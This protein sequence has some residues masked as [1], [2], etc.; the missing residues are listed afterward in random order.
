[1][2]RELVDDLLGFV[3]PRTCL[4]CGDALVHG[5]EH[6]CLACNYDMPRT[7]LHR[8]PFTR[9]SERLARL[10]PSTPVAAWFYYQRLSPWARVVHSAKYGGRPRLARD[11]GRLFTAEI[12]A[13]GFFD[14]VDCL[15]PVPMHF[16]KRLKRGYN[17]AYRIAL[18]VADVTKLPVD[19]SFYARRGHATQTRRT[20]VERSHNVRA[21]MFDV[22]ADSG[23]AGKRIVVIDDIV[24]TGAT[25][26]AV[27][28]TLL[29]KVGV[30]QAKVLC[31]GITEND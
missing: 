24:T 23:L 17:Q 21:D 4:V 12:V 15:V 31:L 1:M 14:D 20:A 11:L 10:Q 3:V 2:I 5:E 6:V 18:G 16:L 26:E 7:Q 19:Q 9:I 13:D 27:V 25:I 8:M 30:S 29:T 22:R 28:D